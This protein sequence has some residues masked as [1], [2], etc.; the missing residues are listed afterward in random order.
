MTHGNRVAAVLATL[1]V[2]ITGP[3][4]AADE[5]LCG[6]GTFA[7]TVSTGDLDGSD[8]VVLV[9]PQ[10]CN[11]GAPITAFNV[12]RQQGSEDEVLL[13]DE[14]I[15]FTDALLY[16]FSS[17]PHELDLLKSVLRTTVETGKPP[18]P[19]KDYDFSDLAQLSSDPDLWPRAISLA[20]QVWQVGV[21]LGH[22]Y[23]DE[24]ITSDVTYSYRVAGVVDGIEKAL[25]SPTRI[26]AGKPDLGVPSGFAVQAGDSQVLITWSD[27]K[28]ATG[29]VVERRET[30]TSAG[31]QVSPWRG[32][33]RM[34]KDLDGKDLPVEK[35]GFIDALRFT[36]PTEELPGFPIF[37]SI[38]WDSAATAVIFGPRNGF[39]Y[40]YRVHAKNL[41]G[42]D[43]PAT[44]WSASVIPSDA[45]PPRAPVGVTAT[46]DDETG[47]I[48]IEW[49]AVT[50]DVNEREEESFLAMTYEV[51]RYESSVQTESQ[52]TFVGTGS[53]GS[54]LLDV[55]NPPANVL[56]PEF[57]N[58]EFYYRVF[59]VDV[60]GNRSSRSGTASAFLEDKTPPPS[61]DGVDAI[62][63]E[64]MI[65]VVWPLLDEDVVKDISAYKIYRSLC[66]FG[67]WD[68]D[69][70]PP[71]GPPPDEEPG[72]A[73]L[74][75]VPSS[76]TTSS[77][78]SGDGCP[79]AWVLLETVSHDDQAK[80]PLTLPE[81]SAD[82]GYYDDK[83]V[84][85]GSPLCYAYLVKALD[86]SGNLSGSW[87]IHPAE[88][89]EDYVCQR[90]R[91]TTPPGAAIITTLAARDEAILIGWI[92]PPVQDIGAY[93][94]FRAT[95]PTGSYAYVGGMTVQTISSFSTGAILH[96]PGEELGPDDRIDFEDQVGCDAI[97]LHT[98][99]EMSSGKLLDVGVDPKK[100]YWYKVIGV[101]QVGNPD[102]DEDE[103]KDALED[104][105]AVSTFTYT[106]MQP[107][108]PVLEPVTVVA[109]GLSLS[110]TSVLPSDMTVGTIIYRSE[111]VAGPYT[112]I[113]YVP[114][115]SP[116]KTFVDRSAIP[117]IWYWYRAAVVNDQGSVSVLSAEKGGRFE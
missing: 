61:P 76:P 56:I 108:P 28:G 37:H 66:A 32:G 80:N 112:E 64:D 7:V 39:S 81:S 48:T 72:P 105:V 85:I 99:E 59:C 69:P 67:T 107:P 42:N 4:L 29:Y 30:G 47:T 44:S 86:G 10:A 45:T 74:V 95:D 20:Q 14:P 91:D 70:K 78:A 27:A 92:A 106:T 116:T 109:D 23:L 65:R 111:A 53:F 49:E 75:P 3:M 88:S 89:G 52:G 16:D 22:G 18:Y 115:S 46:A 8:V 84:V 12:Y 82:F 60:A 9:W 98:T 73:S 50:R 100:V 31:L 15:E 33:T 54:V 79:N 58:Q 63:R 110:W 113:G 6:Q 94:V 26:V 1:V 57:G 71:V 51:Y 104:A 13:N 87:P 62:G 43:G 36:E 24:D 2:L 102:N 40:Q 17:A 5:G 83:D 90:L 38:Q 103:R 11:G 117:G 96:L 97:G 34:S 93:Y 101:D 21:A 55:H 25:G 77:S 19:V 68:C 41:L 35:I 114:S